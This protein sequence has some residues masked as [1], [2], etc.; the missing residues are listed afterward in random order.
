MT[1][2]DQG[3]VGKQA[4]LVLA[5]TSL[6]NLLV[7]LDTS[8]AS[9]AFPALNAA[10]PQASTADLSWV[11]TFYSVALAGFLIV[12]GRIA[13]RVGRL[14]IF[15][16]GMVLFVMA[17][18]GVACAP[19][20]S[21]IIGMR[22]LQG[23][24]AAL[25]TP[26]SLGLLV[27]AWPV[28]RR[29]TAV[30]A[31]GSVLALASSIGPLLGGFIIEFASWRW[32]FLINVPIG[33]FALLWGRKILTESERDGAAATPD[34]IGSMLTIVA[35]SSLLLAIVQ[36]P[37][38]G[39]V[40]Y[41]LLGLIAFFVVTILAL[42]RHTMSHND[43]IMPPILF[44]IRTFRIASIAV[45]LFSLGFLSTFVALVLFLT[46]I[47][48]YS[49]LEAGFAITGLP[50]MA[51]ITAN[52]AGRLAERFGFKA[53]IVPGCAAFTCGA[54]WLWAFMG[55]QPDPLWALFPAT[56]M[57]GI[58]IGAAPA[59]LNG[60]GVAA[61]EPGYFSVAGAVGQTARQ[62]GTAIGVAI[63][64]AIIGNPSDL[65]SSLDAFDQAFLYL[66]IVTGLAGITAMGLRTER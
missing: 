10:F 59:I 21:I 29:T 57:M 16:I 14:R 66:A 43:P 51:V 34:L 30:A 54:L 46:G 63:L 39:W 25:M 7:G 38:W 19:T 2:I 23:F 8:I 61:V 40:S 28:E 24:A 50:V 35:T 15:N 45:F 9:V 53:T 36:G 55:P 48:G 49:A 27:A 31:W 13:D 1:D 62:L 22:G 4:W 6:V 17:S 47:W 32:A 58:G 26:A 18:I 65:A 5:A 60:A 20:V 12:A 44:T 11:L 42:V 52:V 64:V 3:K 37:E 56:I 33:I 41:P